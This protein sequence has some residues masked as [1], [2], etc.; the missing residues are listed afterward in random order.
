LPVPP[1]RI[2]SVLHK[3]ETGP[4]VLEKDFDKRILIPNIK[5]VVKEYDIKYDPNN[6]VPSDDSLA[7]DV[8]NAAVDLFLT[9]GTYC[10]TTQ[11]RMIFTEEELKEALWNYNDWLEIGEGKDRRIWTSRKVEDTKLPGCLFTPVG[12]RCSEENF[13]HMIMAYMQ[14]PL[15]DAVST[16]ILDKVEGGYTKTHSPFE[17]QGGVVHAQYARQAAVRVG[18]PGIAIILTGTALSAAS[19]IASSNPIWGARPTD[20]RLVSV[21]SELKI[22]Y[23]LLN[24]TL[25]FNQ[26]G[27]IIGTLS[28]PLY[29]VY[30]GIEG[31]TV[32]GVASHL[33]G[34][35]VNQGHFTCYFPVHFRYFNN[36]SREMLWLVSLSYQALANNTKLISG[37][38]GFAVAG[39]C[40]EMVLYESAL[41]GLVSAVSGTAILW[42]IASAS[43]KHFERTT[44][45]EAR[46]ACE[47]GIAAVYSKLKRS[48]VNEIVKK[49]L[50]KYEDKID[51]A[52]LGK[53]FPECY[54]VK[55]LKPSDEYIQLYKKVKREL[56]DLGVCYPY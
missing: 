55:S 16:P 26:Y 18:R 15:A 28:G 24:K 14:E 4:I 13:I 45:M 11:R 34:L 56:E 20:L 2:I 5:R 8:W 23:D 52:P 40:T 47:T 41:H 19:Q 1:W 53:T 51:K 17:Q 25:H 22:D 27:G 35:L 36:T 50:P 10:T 31:T 12:V 32:I 54:D 6:P 7:K 30:A 38:N 29:G 37:S 3:A 46:M 33:Q 49:V 44:P 21:I 39:P 43:N 9:V 42:E 48:D